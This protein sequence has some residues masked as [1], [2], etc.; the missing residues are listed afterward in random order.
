[1][2]DVLQ[3]DGRRRRRSRLATKRSKSN[4]ATTSDML[5][6]RWGETMSQVAVFLSP[7]STYAM[8]GRVTGVQGGQPSSE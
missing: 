3:A 6:R 4:P 5:L 7:P 1:M 2:A 8:P